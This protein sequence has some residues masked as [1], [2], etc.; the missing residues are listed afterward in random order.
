MRGLLLL[1][2][3]GGQHG[4]PGWEVGA[5]SDHSSS[6][7]VLRPD[8]SLPAW[9]GPAVP[10]ALLRTG[11]WMEQRVARVLTG[12][13]H[14]PRRH[15]FDQAAGAHPH[16]SCSAQQLVLPVLD[17]AHRRYNDPRINARVVARLVE[18]CAQRNP[19]EAA[20]TTL[21][22]D[23]GV[24]EATDA[25]TNATRASFA[26]EFPGWGAECERVDVRSAGFSWERFIERFVLPGIPALLT[27]LGASDLGPVRRAAAL[28]P[29][30]RVSCT[31][32]AALAVIS[33]CGT[34]RL[35]W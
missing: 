23:V 18:L 22:S 6:S 34:R 4:V 32:V 11:N 31:L 35:C 3:A 20:G 5:V 21:F 33:L 7:E 2:L 26:T 29:H 9:F 14:P 10:E 28:C 8:E 1:I 13:R 30:P 12:L 16:A 17:A 24:D 25:L 27:G 15:P 19:G